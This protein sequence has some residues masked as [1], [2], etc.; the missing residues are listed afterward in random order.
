ML[1]EA[2]EGPFTNTFFVWAME[3]YPNNRVVQAFGCATLV[4]M[5]TL[6]RNVEHG[7]VTFNGLGLF[8]ATMK[9]VSNVAQVEV[10]FRACSFEPS[11]RV[12][13]SHY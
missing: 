1:D 4:N 5:C 7:V 9:E 10:Q 13:G 11:G 6:K 2:K 3:N 12:Q 8:L